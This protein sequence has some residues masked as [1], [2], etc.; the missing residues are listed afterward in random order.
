[1]KKIKKNLLAA[2]LATAAIGASVG[3]TTTSCNNND[4]S[5][6]DLKANIGLTP[7]FIMD[8]KTE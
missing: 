5:E 3:L 7:S 1:M 8:M 2:G 6:H 4:R